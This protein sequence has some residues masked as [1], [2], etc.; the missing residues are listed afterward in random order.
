MLYPS[1][2]KTLP[3]AIFILLLTSLLITADASADFQAEVIELQKGV[4]TSAGVLDK[5]TGAVY[6][7][8]FTLNSIEPGES[9]HLTVTFDYLT[10]GFVPTNIPIVGGSWTMVIVRRGEYY[11]TIYGSVERGEIITD[12]AFCPDHPPSGPTPKSFVAD[13]RSTGVLGDDASFFSY[14][15]LEGTSDGVNTSGFMELVY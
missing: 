1:R 7:N 3:L 11:R 14:A 4:E 9:R 13:L 10:N 12:A 5:N 15:H 8:T 6:G 2:T